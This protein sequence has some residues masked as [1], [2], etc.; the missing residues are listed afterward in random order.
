MNPLAKVADRCRQILSQQQITMDGPGT[1]L[2][3]IETL[4]EFIGPGGLETKSK[5]GNLPAAALPA[6]NAR[7]SQPIEMK[8]TRPLLR[9][10]PNI[11]GL[12]VL[13]RVMD[14]ARADQ[15]RLWINPET[16]KL[17][18]GLN[19]TERYFALLEAWLFCA[20][21]EVLGGA[22]RR[23]VAQFSDNMWFLTKLNTSRWKTFDE[24]CHI[25]TFE[26]AVSTWNTWLQAQFGL[27][28]VTPRPAAGRQGTNRGWIMAAARRTPWGEAVALTVAEA[29]AQDNEAPAL[30]LIHPPEHGGFGFLQPYFQ[31]H[32]PEWKRV[33]TLAEPGF[34][35]GLHIFKVELDDFRAGGSTWRQLAVPAHCS[36]DELASAILDAF[37]FTDHDHLY[38]FRFRDHYGKGRVYYHPYTDEGPYTDG[39]EVGNIGLPEKG[40][41]R[42]LFDYGDS[43]RFKLQ[44][45]R[46]EPGRGGRPKVISSAGRAPKQYPDADEDCEWF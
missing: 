43:W 28:E 24:Y 46:R 40:V 38:E 13:L 10:Y 23:N 42:F 26:G 9:D 15:R 36:L 14:I 25:Y 19:D 20:D 5:Q 16:Q 6:L 41:M 32:F 12:Y 35:E 8:L 30:I 39:I 11:A 3:D 1:I 18:Q 37:K 27:I 22:E 45:E 31:P 29:A 33:F 17:W 44:L 34:Q 4:I 7:L 2:R 21:S